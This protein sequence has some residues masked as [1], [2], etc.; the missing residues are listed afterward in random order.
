MFTKSK[1]NTIERT[2]EKQAEVDA[3]TATLILY[4]FETCPYCARVRGR[5]EALNLN[6][7]KRDIRIEP[8]Y[9][10]ELIDGGGKSQVPALRIAAEDGTVTWMYE[11]SDIIDW[12]NSRFSEG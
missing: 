8:N 6:I 5:M 4:H 7:E 12:L 1:T 10:Q 3:Q 9:R 11:S 2:P